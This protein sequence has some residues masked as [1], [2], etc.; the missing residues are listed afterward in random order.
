VIPRMPTVY[1]KA[2]KRSMGMLCWWD[3][4]IDAGRPSLVLNRIPTYGPE[5]RAPGGVRGVGALA[6]ATDIPRRPFAGA[7]A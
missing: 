5:P 4:W 6:T 3:D 2:T 1:D 7:D